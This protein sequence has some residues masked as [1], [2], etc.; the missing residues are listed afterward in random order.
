MPDLPL[1][2]CTFLPKTCPVCL[3]YT[4][5]TFNA[6]QF[7]LV[8]WF[9]KLRILRTANCKL[10]LPLE[11]KNWDHSYLRADLPRY[12]L[13]VSYT[14]LTC[15]L[16][17]TDVAGTSISD[18][19]ILPDFQ[20]VLHINLS[21]I[22]VSV[23]GFHLDNWLPQN[24]L[25]AQTTTAL[26]GKLPL[27]NYK[28][29]KSK[30]CRLELP[31]HYVE[32]DWK[33]YPLSISWEFHCFECC[34]LPRFFLLLFYQYYTETFQWK[35]KKKKTILSIHHKLYI[36]NLALIIHYPFFIGHHISDLKAH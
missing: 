18:F 8:L 1:L 12:I 32:L 29:L 13:W 16:G 26:G 10:S 14:S 11:P 9:T 2:L 27:K 36:I 28:H 30:F 7:H 33:L 19:P 20:K 24:I 25:S 15:D 35:K 4:H 31:S 22:E 21:S 3:Q 17:L 5:E 6:T 34:K 23:F